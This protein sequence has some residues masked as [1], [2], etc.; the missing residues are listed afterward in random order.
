LISSLDALE[1]AE[2]SGGIRIIA[3]GGAESKALHLR[4]L[5]VTLD[6]GTDVVHEAEVEMN[7]TRAPNASRRK[8]YP[9]PAFGYLVVSSA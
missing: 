7:A 9:P 8:T 5:S 4:G 6:D 3:R 2:K 1:L